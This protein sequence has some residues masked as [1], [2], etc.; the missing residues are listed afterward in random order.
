MDPR[1][2]FAARHDLM[3]RCDLLA[4]PSRSS[5]EGLNTLDHAGVR[6]VVAALAEAGLTASA[7]GVRVLDD[8]VRT[9][10]LAARA[11]GIEVGAIANSLVF[12]A[13][14]ADGSVTPLLAMTSGAHRADPKILAALAG[15]ERIDRA[16]AEFVRANT[17]QAIGGVAPVGHPG[18]IT[19][20]VDTHLTRYPMLWAAAGHP[21]TVFPITYDELVRLTDATAADLAGEETTA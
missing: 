4:H 15:A 17:G 8:E 7:D 16:D 19:T 10:A 1:P 5:G 12:Q 13:V 14:H 2:G 21:K 18:R 6:K 20:L 3:V 9:A 11:L